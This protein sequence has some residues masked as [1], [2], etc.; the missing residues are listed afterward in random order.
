MKK[1][2]KKDLK[3]QQLQLILL[4]ESGTE[5]ILLT[6]GRAGSEIMKKRRG[7]VKCKSLLRPE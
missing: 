5:R 3:F 4:E 1:S 7:D 2:C 6:D